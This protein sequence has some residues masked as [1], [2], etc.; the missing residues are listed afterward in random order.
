MQLYTPSFF[1][2]GQKTNSRILRHEAERLYI[3][4]L[5]NAPGL[6]GLKVYRKLHLQKAQV[7]AYHMGLTR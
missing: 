4:M 6:M 1:V 2:A 7:L 3:A 5:A